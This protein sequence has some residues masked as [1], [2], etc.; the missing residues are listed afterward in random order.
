[1]EGE[2]VARQPELKASQLK[3]RS[4]PL[5]SSLSRTESLS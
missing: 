5:P 3:V 2:A 1:M 4:D